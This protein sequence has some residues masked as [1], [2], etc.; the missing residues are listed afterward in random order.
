MGS[1]GVSGK[2]STTCEGEVLAEDP[3]SPGRVGVDCSTVATR[4]KVVED[5][6]KARAQW[7]D[8]GDDR[9]LRRGLLKVLQ[10]LEDAN[11]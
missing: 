6:E 7:M 8:D 2:V 9:S 5:L 10:R 3:V 11:A 1:D 4:E